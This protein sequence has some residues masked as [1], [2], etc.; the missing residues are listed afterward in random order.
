IVTAGLPGVAGVTID[1]T[2]Q[3]GFDPLT[4]HPVIELTAAPGA[5]AGLLL[6]SG[7][8][9]RGLAINGFSLVG[10]GLSGSGSHVEGCF[11]GTD[12]TGT[13]AVG[14]GTG[15]S[16]SGTGDVV[17]GTTA[18]ARN[19]ISGNMGAGVSGYYGGSVVTAGAGPVAAG[20][21]AAVLPSG[22]GVV[23]GG[24]AAAAGIAINGD[25]GVGVRVS[26]SDNTVEGNFI[27]TDKTGTLALGNTLD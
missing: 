7:S 12:V 20:D 27:G 11:I 9:V 13:V 21:G 24:A 3:P 26:G 1:G 6:G 17:G 25:T 23:V 16:V 5:T 10:V 15:V 2:S 22:T 14:N 19:V 18:A 4:R 8:T